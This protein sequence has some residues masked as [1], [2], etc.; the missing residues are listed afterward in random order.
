MKAEIILNEDLQKVLL[1]EVNDNIN[2]IGKRILIVPQFKIFDC[3]ERCYFG[4][5]FIKDYKIENG[6][7]IITEIIRI[8]EHEKIEAK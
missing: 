4:G 3:P 2:I 8:K 7:V 6:K 5:G 1:Q